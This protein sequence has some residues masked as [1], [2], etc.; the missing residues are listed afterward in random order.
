[1]EAFSEEDPE[2]SDEV[3]HQEH[4]EDEEEEPI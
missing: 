2:A 1:M 3:A 4:E